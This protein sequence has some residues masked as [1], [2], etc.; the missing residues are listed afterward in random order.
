[1]LA[2]K[3]GFKNIVFQTALIDLSGKSLC[4]T[5]KRKDRNENH[6][7]PE[8]INLLTATD[9]PDIKYKNSSS[10]TG[11]FMR[12]YFAVIIYQIQYFRICI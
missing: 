12:G 4:D 2:H 6:S 1:M 10:A 3:G 5:D 8:I 9:L 11:I 7:L